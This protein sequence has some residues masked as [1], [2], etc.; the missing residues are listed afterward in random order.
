MRFRVLLICATLALA[1]GDAFAAYCSCGPAA[2][3]L[4][5]YEKASGVLPEKSLLK[6]KRP[7]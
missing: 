2:D 1:Y 3:V 6:S 7:P 5:S 4:T